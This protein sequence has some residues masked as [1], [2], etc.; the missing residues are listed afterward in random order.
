MFGMPIKVV[1]SLP[2][3]HFLIQSGGV[4]Y[5]FV[6]RVVERWPQERK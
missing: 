3:D 2:S 4:T 6:I 5:T 1:P